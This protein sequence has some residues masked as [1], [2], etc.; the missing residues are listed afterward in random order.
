[1]AD[2]VDALL[3]NILPKEYEG[4]V[5]DPT[6]VDARLGQVGFYLGTEDDA[7]TKTER[8]VLE[9]A[10]QRL[11]MALDRINAFF[12]DDWPAYKQ[13]VEAANPRFFDDYEPITIDD[14]S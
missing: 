3:H 4:I 8:I 1:M 7:P 12:E 9:R 2:S 10:E 13:T 11:R 6:L 5:D 14:D